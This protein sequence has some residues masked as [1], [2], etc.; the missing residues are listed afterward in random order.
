MDHL[1]EQY[2]TY[3]FIDQAKPEYVVKRSMEPCTIGRLIDRTYEKPVRWFFVVFKPYNRAY[4]KDP[5]YFRIKGLS[6]C[7][8]AFIKPEAILLTREMEAEKVHI[9]ALVA[10]TADPSYL[11]EKSYCNKYKVYVDEVCTRSSLLRVKDY[12]LKESKHR[13]FEKYLDYIEWS[14]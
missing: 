8:D 7:R 5:A 14:R 1:Q 10:T 11:H 13:T 12:I 6:K 2:Q 3:S 4:N 9:N